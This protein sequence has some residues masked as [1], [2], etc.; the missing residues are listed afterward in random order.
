[1]WL[2]MS[3]V[4]DITWNAVSSHQKSIFLCTIQRAVIKVCS[5]TL[6]ILE[7]L[8][9]NERSVCS[10]VW[11]IGKYLD[12]IPGNSAE[13]KLRDNISVKKS[14]CTNEPWMLDAWN[15]NYCNWV[16]GTEISGLC[17]G[18]AWKKITASGLYWIC[19]SI[20]GSE[21]VVVR[22]LY[23]SPYTVCPAPHVVYRWWVVLA[24]TQSN[25]NA[26]DKSA[27]KLH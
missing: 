9:T 3:F 7:V 21:A 15:F 22:T 27:S 14:R 4:I 12:L 6:I 17:W 18:T 2:P 26:A 24:K 5:F 1:M 20:I 11:P 23:I 8:P 16:Q 25:T 10:G 19:Q 13:F